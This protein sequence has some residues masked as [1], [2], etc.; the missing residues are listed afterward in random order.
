MFDLEEQQNN[1]NYTQSSEWNI[2]ETKRGEQCI[3]VSIYEGL[4]VDASQMQ[5]SL[6]DDN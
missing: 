6:T 3:T 1:K 4:N 2:Q 5:L